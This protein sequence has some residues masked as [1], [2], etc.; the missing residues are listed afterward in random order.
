MLFVSFSRRR[1]SQLGGALQ[2]AHHTLKAKAKAMS[3][4]Y[5]GG[6]R[7]LGP[8]SLL[9]Q[10]V[11]AVLASGQSV[12]VGCSAGA[13]A[14]VIQSVRSSSFSQVRVFAAFAQSGAGSCSVS[15][16]QVVS[17]FAQAGGSVQWLAGG[18][19]AVPLAGRLIQRS[20]AALRGCSVALFFSPGAGSLASASHALSKGIQ[21]FAF[22]EMPGEVPG[23]PGSWVK[24]VFWSFPCWQFRP[25]QLSLF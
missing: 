7:N 21:V 20:I 6:S 10:V 2:K 18:S 4:V 25:A 9:S 11:A 3:S 1:A 14:L 17:Q 15:A 24:S 13:D 23:F 19:L 16:V 8:S 12:H 22:G 5:F